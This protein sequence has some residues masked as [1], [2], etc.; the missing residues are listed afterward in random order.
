MWPGPMLKENPF[1]EIRTL[2]LIIP[3][4]KLWPSHIKSQILRTFARFIDFLPYLRL[5]LGKI[6]NLEIMTGR[7]REKSV[8]NRKETWRE[9]E[10]SPLQRK[11][12]REREKNVSL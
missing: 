1:N 5:K 11:Q 9:R 4:T 12:R 3:Y 6:T 8:H 7:E 2:H 10:V